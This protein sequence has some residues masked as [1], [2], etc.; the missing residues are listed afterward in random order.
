M[1]MVPPAVRTVGFAAVELTRAETV[2]LTVEVPSRPPNEPSRPALA[3]TTVAAASVNASALIEMLPPT[4]MLPPAPI[5]DL[6][7]ELMSALTTEKRTVAISARSVVAPEECA[8]STPADST[9][10][11]LA[12]MVTLSPTLASTVPEA[13]DVVSSR[14]MPIALKLKLLPSD[15]ASL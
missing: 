4:L 6:T 1:V 10:R 3:P 12:L 5:V 2:G 7:D 8:R 14:P 15:E 13:V 9:A 11:L